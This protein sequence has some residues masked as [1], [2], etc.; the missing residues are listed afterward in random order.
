MGEEFAGYVCDL[1]VLL[2]VLNSFVEVF[3]VLFTHLHKVDTNAVIR[4][5]FSMHVSDCSTNLEE[6]FV[7]IYC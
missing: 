7:L 6:L 5:S 1:F 3:R 4:K 2:V